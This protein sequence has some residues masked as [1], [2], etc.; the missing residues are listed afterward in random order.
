MSS[1][2]FGLQQKKTC[3][4][5]NPILPTLGSME[6]RLPAPAVF[7]NVSAKKNTSKN[8]LTETTFSY[9]FT[10]TIE[11]WMKCQIFAEGRRLAKSRKKCN[12]CNGHKLYIYND[13][14]A[15]RR[16][17]KLNCITKNRLD[18]SKDFKDGFRLLCF[19][20][21][22]WM[23]PIRTHSAGLFQKAPWSQPS[24]GLKTTSASSFTIINHHER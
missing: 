24:L 1:E 9:L 4:P 5:N 14:H 8:H 23:S 3:E 2:S 20:E 12:V 19:I 18:S 22:G 17:I 16:S 7:S 11:V 15:C 21:S 6:P 13:I 10:K